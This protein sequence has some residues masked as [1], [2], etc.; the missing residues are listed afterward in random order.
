[1]G[2]AHGA[3]GTDV[4]Y[5]DFCARYGNTITFHPLPLDGIRQRGD[6]MKLSLLQL[7]MVVCYGVCSSGGRCSTVMYDR[8][9][10][11]PHFQV[12]SY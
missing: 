7:D 6:T 9:F 4:S 5:P 3:K 8:V 1:M 12:V 10:I 2:G 11:R